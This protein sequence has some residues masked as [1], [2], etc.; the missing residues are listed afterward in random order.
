MKK[1]ILFILLLSAIWNVF[2]QNADRDSF[3]NEVK[4]S[5]DVRLFPMIPN[6]S[7]EDSLCC[8]FTFSQMSC[9][10]SWVQATYAT[11]DY[12][13]CGYAF[14]AITAA[15]LVPFPDG[16]AAVGEIFSDQ[17]LEYVGV[18]LSV[19]LFPGITYE[20]SM[21]IAS[22]P[23]N[24][25]G[26]V[27]DSGTIFYGP[28]DVTIFGNPSCSELPFFST[29]VCPDGNWVPIAATNYTPVSNWDTITFVFTPTDTMN[30]IMFGAP[31]VLPMEY[32]DSVCKPYFIFDNFTSSVNPIQ[33]VAWVNQIFNIAPN[34]TQGEIII[35]S[36]GLSNF[37]ID[38]FSITGR[39]LKKVKINSKQN[40][41]KL[42]L[43]DLPN[44]I[45]FINL[46]N[47]H[48]SETHKIVIQKEE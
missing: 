31:C 4:N 28:I 20:I 35:S 29:M 6:P 39:L 43:K 21:N 25:Y 2:S 19:P 40:Q 17:W 12:F 24:D 7:F 42:K 23:I 37:D 9:A 1:N 22:V 32:I 15:G 45:Y 38:V 13:N 30:A 44:G 34:P 48:Y 14:D 10:D 5:K 8:P 18:C 46:H 36:D 16:T 26:E 41:N 47:N 27:C 11:P 33:D 3:N